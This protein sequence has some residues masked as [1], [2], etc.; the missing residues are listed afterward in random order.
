M[1]TKLSIASS[2]SS[3]V[4]PSEDSIAE[5]F[6]NSLTVMPCTASGVANWTELKSLRRSTGVPPTSSM[7]SVVHPSPVALA[8]VLSS[9][10]HCSEILLML[11]E[12]LKPEFWLGMLAPEASRITPPVPG[13]H[14]I[15]L[16]PFQDAML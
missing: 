2:R 3:E 5:T 11:A 6:F 8:T 7:F 15:Q 13:A 16:W 9:L 14:H 4:L 1:A 12:F 10:Y